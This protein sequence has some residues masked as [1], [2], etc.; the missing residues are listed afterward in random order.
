MG[1]AGSRVAWLGGWEERGVLDG[2]NSGEAENDSVYKR[3][4][5]PRLPVFLECKKTPRFTSDFHGFLMYWHP[6]RG[7]GNLLSYKRF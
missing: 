1:M 2:T 3:F 6:R 5:R 7:L 4:S